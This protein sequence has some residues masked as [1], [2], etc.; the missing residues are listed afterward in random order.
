MY[1][2]REH[3]Q[4]S[5]YCEQQPLYAVCDHFV[6]HVDGKYRRGCR[7]LGLRRRRF[8]GAHQDLPRR[9]RRIYRAAERPDAAYRAICNHHRRGAGGHVDLTQWHGAADGQRRSR[10]LR[11]ERPKQGERAAAAAA[12]ARAARPSAKVREP[13]RGRSAIPSTL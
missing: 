3:V 13:R 6:G 10:P 5:H 8:S 11:H 12:R 4:E 2:Q 7:H 9:G 1:L